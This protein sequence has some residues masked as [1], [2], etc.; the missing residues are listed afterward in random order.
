MKNFSRLL[1]EKK[2]KCI[3]QGMSIPYIM[4]TFPALAEVIRS[5]VVQESCE[6]ESELASLIR[7]CPEE[8]LVNAIISLRDDLTS[9][10]RP[11]VQS[12]IVGHSTI[13]PCFMVAP[14]E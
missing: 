2:R 14:T 8:F 5:E 3:G 4:V 7:F 13:E 6:E 10:I 1:E 12:E 11:C 9:T